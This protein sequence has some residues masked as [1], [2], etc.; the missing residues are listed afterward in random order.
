MGRLSSEILIKLM[1][2]AGIDVQVFSLRSPGVE[3]LDPDAAIHLARETNDWLAN[4]IHRHPDRFAGLAALPTMEPDV[5]ANELKRMVRDH[6]FVGA[7]I[8]GPTRG[9]DLDDKFF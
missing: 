4:A 5:A 1:D 6:G 2:A 8:K 7:V 9:H 3:Q